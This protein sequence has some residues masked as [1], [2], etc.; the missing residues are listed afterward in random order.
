MVN[1]L[2]PVTF[3]IIFTIVKSACQD[4]TPLLTPEEIKAMNA[5]LKADTNLA[6]MISWFGEPVELYEKYKVNLHKADSIWMHDQKNLGNITD[7]GYT[8]HF[9][10]IPLVDWFTDSDSLTGEPGVAYLIKTDEATILFDVGL[11]AKKEDPSPLM[12]N[13]DKLGIRLEDIDIIVI[14]H[15]HGDHVGGGQW[16]EKN[17]F[18]LTGHQTDLGQKKVYTPVE[19]TYPGLNPVFTPKPLKIANGVATTGV[20]HY[21]VFFTDIGEQAL[22]VNV[23]DK[24]LVIISGCGHQTIER[25][26]Q[27]TEIL[28]NEPIYAVFGGFHYPLEEMRNITPMYKYVITGKLPWERLTREDVEYNVN[29]MKSTGVKMAGLSGHD[30]CDKSI[31]VFRDVFQDSYRDIAVG[32]KIIIN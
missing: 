15:N 7:I 31:S 28:S 9:E 2:I 22:V 1:K 16:A 32:R 27:R 24:G 5:A 17:T 11:N 3:L 30:S 6:S 10:M 8:R 19:M 29:L 18:S 20:I 21:P 13:M 26:L 4:K 12:R 14:S 23:K 25:I